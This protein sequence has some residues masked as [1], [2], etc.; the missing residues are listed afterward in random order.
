MPPPY[1]EEADQWALMVQCG[2]FPTGWT[3]VTGEIDECGVSDD[4]SSDSIR[5]IIF[6]GSKRE[7]LAYAS[8]ITLAD[9]TM[10][11]ILEEERVGP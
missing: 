4:P 6:T 5:R 11:E 8:Q 3:V 9:E 1:P 7:A 10:E 2:N